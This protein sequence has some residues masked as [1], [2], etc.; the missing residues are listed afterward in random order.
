MFKIFKILLFYAVVFCGC[1]DE[2]S[3]MNYDRNAIPLDITSVDMKYIKS[4]KMPA[5]LDFGADDCEYCVR[6]RPTLERL[7]K[8]LQGKAIVHFADI[9]KR[10]GLAKNLPVKFIPTQIFINADGSAF[11]PSEILERS[12]NLQKIYAKNDP[13]KHLYTIHEGELKQE[14]LFDIL[15]QM[16]VK[17]SSSEDL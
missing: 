10:P 13:S 6:M 17:V 2:K 11:E 8:A 16:G 12:L 4:K 5:V 15:A 14:D 9:G 1:N 7:N 3:T